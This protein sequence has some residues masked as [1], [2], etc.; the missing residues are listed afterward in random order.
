MLSIEEVAIGLLAAGYV[1]TAL[2]RDGMVCLRHTEHTHIL[3][4]LEEGNDIADM[5]GKGGREHEDNDHDDLVGAGPAY[6][7]DRL[8]TADGL[9]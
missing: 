7:L 2:H 1:R 9:V 5:A 6:P 4:V 3:L 8:I